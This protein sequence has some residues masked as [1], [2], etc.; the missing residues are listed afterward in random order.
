MVSVC[1]VGMMLPAF[2]R[3]RSEF[4]KRSLHEKRRIY[5]YNVDNWPR[6]LGLEAMPIGDKDLSHPDERCPV[7]DLLTEIKAK[8]GE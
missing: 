6:H 8:N 2:R 4:M 5:V 3:R 1:P 7:A